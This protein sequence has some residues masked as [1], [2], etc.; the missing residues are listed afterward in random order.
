M[1]VNELFISSFFY[2]NRTTLYLEYWTGIVCKLYGSQVYI[3]TADS[4]NLFTMQV[5]AE[6]SSRAFGYQTHFLQTLIDKTRGRERADSYENVTCIVC[7]LNGSQVY[8]NRG[9]F[10]LNNH[11][12]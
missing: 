11:A 10:Q 8:K 3:K 6:G 1:N 4:S 2:R 7:K 9:L 5:G 12:G